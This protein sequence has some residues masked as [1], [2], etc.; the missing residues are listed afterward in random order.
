MEQ[1]TDKQQKLA[2]DYITFSKILLTLASFLSLGYFLPETF[3]EQKET[4]A[5][6]IIGILLSVSIFFHL[7]A[8]RIK[9]KSA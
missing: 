8:K 4:A 3:S 7:F 9:D 2:Q 1:H 6:I 5:L